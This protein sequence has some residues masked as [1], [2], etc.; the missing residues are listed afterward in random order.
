LF[1]NRNGADLNATQRDNINNFIGAGGGFLAIHDGLQPE[2]SW[3]LYDS[4]IGA[5]LAGILRSQ[6]MTLL[7]TDKVHAATRELPY[8]QSWTST[9]YDFAEGPREQAHILLSVRKLSGSSF[10]G[11]HPVSWARLYG[12]GR[13]FA[14]TLGAAATDFGESYFRDHLLGAIEWCGVA[15]GGDVR[16]TDDRAYDLAVLADNIEAC[17]AMDIAADGRVF[18]AEKKGRIFVWDPLSQSSKKLLDWSN[19]G[20]N[21]KVYFPFENGLLGL[22]LDPDFPKKPYLYIHYAYTGSDPWG[23]GIGQHRVSRLEFINDSIDEQSEEVFLAYDFNRDAQIHSAGCLTFDNDGNLL[24]A[25]GDNTSYGAGATKNPYNPADPR[26]GNEIYD[27]QRSSANTADFRG[28]ILRIHPSDTIGGGYDLPAGNLF[29]DSD[30]T[31]GE[32]YIMGVRNPFKLCVDPATN[33]LVWGDVGPDAVAYDSR[34]PMGRDEF[35]LAKAAGN[36]GWPYMLADNRPYREYDYVADS[37]GNWFDPNN[38]HN[39][40]PN[41]DGI[42]PLPPAQPALMWEDKNLFTPEWPEFG[43]GNITAMAGA[44]YRYD[45]TIADPNKLPEYYDRTLFVMDW[46]RDWI[47]AVTLD[48]LGEVVKISP[49]LDSLKFLG[50]MDLKVGPDGALYLMEWRTDKWGGLSSRIVRIRYAPDGRSPIAVIEANKDNGDGPL[51]VSFEGAKSYNPDQLALSYLWDFG[52]GSPQ[53]N[54]SQVSH[55]YLSYGV[56]NAVLEVENSKGNRATASI[57]ITVGNNRPEVNIDFPFHGGLFGWGESIDFRFSIHDREDGNSSDGSLDCSK[58]EARLLLG[59][60]AHAHPSLPFTQCEG[61]FI[62]SE[63][64]HV[65]TDDELYL[66]FE[67]SYTDSSPPSSGSLRSTAIHLLQPK[68]KQAEHYDFASGFSTA[69]TQDSIS[70][71]DIV[72]EEDS[73]WIAIEPLNFYRINSFKLRLTGSGGKVQLWK[74]GLDGDGLLVV[75]SNLPSSPS[76]SAFVTTPAILFTDPGGTDR[77]YFRFVRDG[78]KGLNRLNWIEFE[79]MGISVS[80]DSEIVPDDIIAAPIRWELYPNPASERL[81]IDLH[82]ESGEV[83]L[84]LLNIQGKVLDQKVVSLHAGE[85]W[86]G[87]F[88]LHGLPSGLYFIQL[89][90]ESFVGYG[91]IVVE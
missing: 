31:F 7:N 48:S 39:H 26:S 3:T 14:T 4:I 77:Y 2:E 40:S 90:K 78:Q 76:G 45:S 66:L 87:S 62:P 89:R 9:W 59:H 68:L 65:T 56:Y 80:N 53:Q 41:N 1:L 34:G 19:T 67:A 57:T 43:K 83:K 29:A 5:K 21:H 60:D 44:F 73:A 10:R 38:L 12:R 50:P 54:G 15:L 6:Q 46:T 33:W 20:A 36:Y 27:A 72:M 88:G 51:T 58:A 17:M 74:G 37:S 81:W 71:S 18:Y 52:D 86:R 11:E 84:Q 75:E 13:V 25:T 22:A 63:E 42:G 24:I 28:K 47:K 8:R 82:G 55:T 30:S 61:S 79:G 85:L 69:P 49:F 91:K 32:I 35:N 23:P 64:G 70:V 16:V